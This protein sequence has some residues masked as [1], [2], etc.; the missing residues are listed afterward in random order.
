M[1]VNSESTRRTG[2]ILALVAAMCVVAASCQGPERAGDVAQAAWDQLMAALFGADKP[3]GARRLADLS[4]EERAIAGEF[5]TSEPSWL[6]ASAHRQAALFMVGEIVAKPK[7]AAPAGFALPASFSDGAP[8]WLD[9]DDGIAA[10]AE[11]AEEVPADAAETAPESD[12]SAAAEA[13]A[14]TETPDIAE[15][16]PA[17][18]ALQPGAA[19]T[20]ASRARVAIDPEAGRKAARL[21][22]KRLRERLGEGAKALQERAEARRAELDVAAKPVQAMTTDA[23]RALARGEAQTKA[24]AALARWGVRPSVTSVNERGFVTIEIGRDADPIAFAQSDE[25]GAGGTASAPE[26]DLTI[27]AESAQGGCADLNAVT[28]QQMSADPVLA[29]ECTIA[30]LRATGE[31]EFVEPNYVFQHQAVFRRP[32]TE[33]AP[34]PPPNDPLLSFQ[35]N[36]RPRGVGVGESAEGAGFSTFWSRLRQT[37]SPDVVVAVIDT[38]LDLTHPDI[39]ASTSIMPGFDMVGDLKMGNDGDGRDAD[40]QDPGDICDPNNPLARNSFHGTHVAGIVGAAATNNGAGI[41]GGV[42]SA[43]IVPIRAIGRC[44]GR[45]SDIND[46][47]RWAAGL[48]PAIDDR[49]NAVMNDNP[50]DIINLS[51]GLFEAC[52][53]SMQ[54]AINDAVSVGAI[55]VAAAGN[56]RVPTRFFAPAGCQNVVT[57]AAGDARGMIAPY[58]NYGAEVDILAPGGD[59]T[60]DDD[61]DGRPDGI[62]STK[63]ASDCLDPVTGAGVASCAYAYENGTSMAAPHVAAALALLKGL[64]PERNA[65][66]IVDVLLRD[67]ISPRQPL[68]CAGRCAE[69]P[70]ATPIEGSEGMCLRA[71]GSGL[72]DLTRLT[73]SGASATRAAL[74]AQSR[75]TR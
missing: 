36:L 66:Q 69:F 47:I 3:D 6:Q 4:V 2:K 30:A 20:D 44:G 63:T 1:R 18:G 25:V 60:R 59:L 62:L 15:A 65:A 54:Q 70:Q 35:W 39:R 33:G 8:T 68:E 37:G 17:D 12:A 72:L 28:A 27:A 16:T 10:L 31:F 13:S 9:A 75:W 67:A 50:A 46:A 11:E 24:R 49:G 48:A 52:P 29:T 21:G 19:S 53:Q 26:P 32:D 45:L 22:A 71:C 74:P 51:L 38:G 42:W 23:A 5:L 64:Y 73:P 34:L 43:K 14:A 57:V 40:P 56:S 61:G 55:V 41:A 7:V 58:S